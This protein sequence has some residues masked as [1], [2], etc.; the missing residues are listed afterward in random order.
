M[1]CF[2]ATFLD[3]IYVFC[4]KGACPVWLSTVNIEKRINVRQN[5]AVNA[6]LMFF[7][8]SGHVQRSS[9]MDMWAMRA[10]MARHPLKIQCMTPT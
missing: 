9:L 5:P 7:C 6:M 3:F 2:Q 1:H 4:V 8:V 10:P